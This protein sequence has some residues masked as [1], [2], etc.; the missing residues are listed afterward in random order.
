MLPKNRALNDLDIKN[1]ANDFIPNFRGVF[2][3]NDFPKK[4]LKKEC[5][6]I[7]LDN[8]EGDGTHWCAYHKVNTKCYYF[9]SFGNLRPPIELVHYLG[10]KC[11]ILYNHKRYQ[12]FNTF[13]CG[14][15]CM[16]F[17]LKMTMKKY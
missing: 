12:D 5:G 9:D 4:C 14:H 1:F 13:N 3:R 16:D 8:K 2:M 11:S 15:L 10:S 6:V 7:N 17:L